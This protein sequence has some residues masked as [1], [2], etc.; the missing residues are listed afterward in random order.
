MPLARCDKAKRAE[1]KLIDLAF[2][3]H[4]KS[5]Q[6]LFSCLIIINSF[7]QKMSSRITLAFLA[8]CLIFTL[9]PW[10]ANAH[11]RMVRITRTTTSSLLYIKTF[12]FFRLSQ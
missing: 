1:K 2:L 5:Q 8:L 11:G 7:N 4:I 9:A 3:I 12:L 6:P 10:T